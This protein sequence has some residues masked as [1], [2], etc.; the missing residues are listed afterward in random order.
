MACDLGIGSVLFL[1]VKYSKPK[2]EVSLLSQCSDIDQEE[3]TLVIVVMA[4]RMK[5][6]SKT[7]LRICNKE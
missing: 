7:V 4:L 6:V 2:H 5:A 1:T 3:L